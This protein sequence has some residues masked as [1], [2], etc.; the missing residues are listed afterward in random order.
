MPNSQRTESFGTVVDRYS[1]WVGVDSDSSKM[2]IE[3]TP[4]FSFNYIG[5]IG[6]SLLT[7]IFFAADN[8][9]D[10]FSTILIGLVSWCGL[11]YYTYIKRSVRCLI[12]KN[13]GRIYYFRGGLL[14]TKYE[15]T[16][17]V[18]DIKDIKYVAM[19]R[20]VRRYGDEFQIHFSVDV[21]GLLALSES[22]LGFSDCQ[23]YAE[24]IRDFTNTAMPIKAMD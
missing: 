13:S 23:L 20:E 6:L 12:D 9:T 10:W 11:L 17:S 16:E 21:W 19:T 7:A 1:L 18:H 22:N 4:D 2:L 14:N 8:V 15:E 3:V 5:L 24:K